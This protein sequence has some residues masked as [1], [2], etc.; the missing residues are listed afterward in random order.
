[1]NSSRLR[2]GSLVFLVLAS[3][4]ACQY[5]STLHQIDSTRLTDNSF[6]I[7]D[8][9]GVANGRLTLE[10]DAAT[11]DSAHIEFALPA[12]SWSHDSGSTGG[13]AA[14]ETHCAVEVA[15]KLWYDDE[16]KLV[17]SLYIYRSDSD[18][19]CR[20][21]GVPCVPIDDRVCEVEFSLL[22]GEPLLQS[23]ESE[24]EVSAYSVIPGGCREKAELEP[25]SGRFDMQA[26]DR[27]GI[28]TRDL[29]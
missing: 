10:Y 18:G 5:G 16:E 14:M 26:E 2:I 11:S 28:A 4:G 25:P 27:G 13:Y 24:G 29:H 1:M 23:I 19:D 17:V 3:I 12:S 21:G 6:I 22:A 8:E 7:E 15:T 20:E 9:L